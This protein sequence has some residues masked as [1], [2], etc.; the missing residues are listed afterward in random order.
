MAD[1]RIDQLTAATSLGDSDLL[2]VEQSSTAKK[3]TGTVVSNYINS[4]FGLTGM[5]S[6][7]STLQTAVAG[8]QDALTL[9]LPVSQGG[10]GATTVGNARVNLGLGTAATANIDDTLTISG[11]AADANVVGVQLREIVPASL[12]VNMDVLPRFSRTINGGNAWHPISGQAFPVVIEIPSWCKRISFV[13]KS[14]GIIAFLTSNDTTVSPSFSASYPGRI[15]LADNVE[16]TYDVESDMLYMYVLRTSG[17]GTDVSITDLTF[18]SIFTDDTLSIQ[19]AAA[20]AKATGDLIA[21]KTNTVDTTA[22][23]TY[24]YLLANVSG[25]TSRNVMVSEGWLDTPAQRNGVFYNRQG[26]P[27]HDIQIFIDHTSGNQYNRIIRRSSRSVY[28]DW[29]AT[30]PVPLLKVVVTGDSIC[31]GGRNNGK[32]FI[33]DVGGV[34]ANIGIGGATI[35]NVH[36]SSASTDSVHPMGAANIPDTIVKYA[37]QAAETW[38]IEPDAIIAE[39]GINDMFQNAVLGTVPTSP[40]RND[41]DAAALDLSTVTGGL[42]FMFYQMV[43][44]FPNAH[45]FFLMMNRVSNKPWA[46]NT[47]GYTQTQLNEAITAVCKLYG[48]DII[49]VFDKSFISSTFSQYVSPTPYSEDHTVTDLYY[50]DHDMIHPLALGYRAGYA[51]LV[52]EALRKAKNL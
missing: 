45:R 34:Y 29:V 48:V 13:A 33:G 6:D 15:A 24:S 39:G 28:R 37:Q 47:A 21:E 38:Y 20:D 42:G 1:K 32:G 44:L 41:T 49:D 46:A 23:S 5:A 27:N 25:E 3:A 35:S 22:A 4:K 12:S 8:K 16:H 18:Y 50:I 14:G 26:G 43:K 11:G 2:V 9:P 52:K 30:D 10:T 31:R 51:P 7:I 40:A 19:G 36:D 17:A